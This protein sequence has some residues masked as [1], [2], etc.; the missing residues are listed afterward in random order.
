[1]DQS[2]QKKRRQRSGCLLSELIP[3]SVLPVIPL[4]LAPRNMRSNQ[5]YP[6]VPRKV[7]KQCYE[8]PTIIRMNKMYHRT[9]EVGHNKEEKHE[10]IRAIRDATTESRPY[11]EWLLALLL[12]GSSKKDVLFTA[13]LSER[14]LPMTPRWKTFNHFEATLLYSAFIL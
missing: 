8:H 6:D 10:C 9:N 1:V 12:R 7:R 3:S 5:W 13:Y 2:R 11:S 14:N 4:I